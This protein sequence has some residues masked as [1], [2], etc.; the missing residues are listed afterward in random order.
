MA[1][2]Q[3][4]TPGELQLIVLFFLGVAIMLLVIG[5]VIMGVGYLVMR[6][7]HGGD[8]R[9]AQLESRIGKLEAE[10]EELRAELESL[11]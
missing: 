6:F 1:L 8:N 5:A 11:R 7:R 4:P 2:L 3:L 10:N 9:T